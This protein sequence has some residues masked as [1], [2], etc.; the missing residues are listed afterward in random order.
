[1]RKF[2]NILDSFWSIVEKIT[3][4][5]Y[6]TLCDFSQLFSCARNSLLSLVQFLSLQNS[7]L[8]TH[9]KHLPSL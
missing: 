6:F 1:M 4:F 9:A 2:S 5:E 8:S 3:T 7:Y